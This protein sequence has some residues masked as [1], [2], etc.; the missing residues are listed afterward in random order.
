[1]KAQ[2]EQIGLKLPNIVSK[3]LLRIPYYCLEDNFI[4]PSDKTI[5]H[6]HANYTNQYFFEK[7][8]FFRPPHGFFFVTGGLAKT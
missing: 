7:K 5:V 3:I 8:H 1:M 2:E 4:S 6:W